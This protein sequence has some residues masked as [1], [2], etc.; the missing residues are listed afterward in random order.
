MTLNGENWFEDIQKAEYNKSA[1]AIKNL[2]NEKSD[3]IPDI[4]SICY[5]GNRM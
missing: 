2:K 1:F 3:I 5:Y 4:T